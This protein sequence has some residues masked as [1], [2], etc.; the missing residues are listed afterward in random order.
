MGF[1]RRKLRERFEEKKPAA[2]KAADIMMISGC[3]DVQTSADVSNVASFQLPDPAGRAGG[4]CTSALLNVLYKDHAKLDED[5]SF[6]EV[7]TR[8][9][10]ML[11]SKKYEQIPQVRTLHCVYTI[12]MVCLQRS[13]RY[14]F[15]HFTHSCHTT[16][17]FMVVSSPN[18][19]S[20]LLMRLMSTNPLISSHPRLP[21]RTA[22][23]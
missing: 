7:L 18:T 5:L 22:P 2:L 14:V 17:P 10:E 6:T 3:E 19:S 20:R 23:S 1:L 9:R 8:M 13:F 4:A 15:T 16:C 11:Q 21:A 12:C